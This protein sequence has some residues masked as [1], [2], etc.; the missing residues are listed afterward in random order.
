MDSSIESKSFETYNHI[1][2]SVI[3]AQVNVAKAVNSAMV[4]AYWE[5]GEQIYI[6]CG[7]NDR[8]EYGKGLIKYLSEELTKEFG[9]GFTA[10]N[11]NPEMIRSKVVLPHPDG[12]KSAI[13]SPSRT[14]NETFLTANASSYF[15]FIFSIWIC[16]KTFFLFSQ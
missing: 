7:E 12:P 15:L 4:Q 1:R 3:T 16:I 10:A 5:I 8:A 2:K 6:S 9:K 13:S 14:D 11:L